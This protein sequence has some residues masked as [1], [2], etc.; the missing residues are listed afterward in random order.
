[1]IT[2]EQISHNE[3]IRTYIRKED[4]ALRVLGFT[5]HSFPHVTK[6]A[7]ESGEILTA[8]G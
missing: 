5:E 4:E 1:M 7:R 8:L 2:F 6:V 3:Q